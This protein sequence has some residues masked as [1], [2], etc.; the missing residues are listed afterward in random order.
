MPLNME[1]KELVTVKEQDYLDQDPPLRG[2]SYVCMSFVSPED[3]LQRK[4]LFTVHKFLEHLSGDLDVLLGNLK[5]KFE[6]DD[7]IKEMV[8]S[9]REKYAY[10]WKLEELGAEYDFYRHSKQLELDKEFNVKNDFQTSVRGIK[11]RG[12]YEDMQEAISRAKAIKRFDDKFHVYIAQMGCWCPWS[13]NPDDV[14]EH[15]YAETHLNTLVKKYKENQTKKDQLYDDRKKQMMQNIFERNK[16]LT[17]RSDPPVVMERVYDEGESS[18]TV[19]E[20]ITTTAP[21]VEVVEEPETT[22]AV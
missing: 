15:E 2:Q 8:S 14:A 6:G 19:A 10:M 20:S 16:E 13:P 7:A 9:L 12:V 21:V 18:G 22:A 11:I 5:D 3:T 4:E 17:R 1:S